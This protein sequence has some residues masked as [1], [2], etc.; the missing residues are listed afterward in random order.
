MASITWIHGPS[1]NVTF[2][3]VTPQRAGVRYQQPVKSAGTIQL[4]GRGHRERFCRIPVGDSGYE[5]LALR[6]CGQNICRLRFT[7]AAVV[8]DMRIGP[9]LTRAERWHCGGDYW[10]PPTEL[11]GRLVNLDVIPGFSN[12]EPVVANHPIG[13]L[14]G[15]RYPDSLIKPD[16]REFRRASAFRG[17][18]FKSASSMVVRL[19]YGITYN[20]SVYQIID[21]QMEQ[22]AP[23][24]KSL[25]VPNSA[26]NPL[27][28]ANGFNASSA[29]VSTDNFGNRSEFPDRV[30]A[31]LECDNPERFA[32][33]DGDVG[34]LSGD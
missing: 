33:R 22:Q 26:S 8:D 29:G 4:P 25:N 16:K 2:Q 31:D 30:R 21:A 17:V 27:T 13:P 14:T 5:L 32:G 3:R 9:S 19:G 1:L 6:K 18:P 28:L 20:T 10:S 23:L 12:A 7:T 34:D 15:M 11:Y 24:S